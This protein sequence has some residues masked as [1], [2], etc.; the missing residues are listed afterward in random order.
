MTRQTNYLTEDE[1]HALKSV[2][3]ASLTTALFNRGIRTAHLADV[4]P[5]RPDLRLVGYAYTLRYIPMREDL[6]VD[7]HFD[8]T[9]NPQRVSVEDVDP[10][11]VL[12]IDARGETGAGVLGDILITRMQQRGVAGIVTDGAF[13][14]TP[15]IRTI[16]LPTYCRA[17]APYMSAILHH[18][19]DINTPIACGNAAVMPG[20]VIV[21]DGEGVVV[22]PASMAGE[23]ARDAYAKEQY[24]DWA[25][26]R[27]QQ[28]SSILDVY[29]PNDAT[30]AEYQREQGLGTRD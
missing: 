4:H 25:L 14:D 16:D 7:S 3:V 24:E 20:D 23:I 12:V 22:L 17:S 10:G 21:G 13:R 27:I 6:G 18:P 5:V 15:A 1:V 11:D 29:P 2:S 9:T 28:G 19:V 26:K 8:N 30:Y